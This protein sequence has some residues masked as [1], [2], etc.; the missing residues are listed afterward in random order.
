MP[1]ELFNLFFGRYP[2]RRELVLS[3][4]MLDRIHYSCFN[5]CVKGVKIW[6]VAFVQVC[7]S[8]E[9]KLSPVVSNIKLQNVITSLHE[10]ES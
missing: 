9:V 3:Q 4:F 1:F 8:L 2:F 5:P 10:F 7:H 6:F